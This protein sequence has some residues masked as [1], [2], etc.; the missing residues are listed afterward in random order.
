MHRI[1]VFTLSLAVAAPAAAEVRASSAT[2]FALESRATV[3][4]PPADVYAAL[5][6][7]GRWWDPQHTYSG[8]AAN[9]TLDPRVDGCFCEA[10]PAGGGSI[11]HGR[12]VY[13]RPGQTLRFQ[14]ALGPLQSEGVTGSLTWSLRAVDGGTEITQ[15]YV[16]GGYMRGGFEPVAPI[17]DRVMNTQ[18]LRLANYIRSPT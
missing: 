7:I 13:A 14:G 10:I 6:R 8:D 1:C 5:A 15:T 9:L 17:V 12:V 16:V 4:V 18:L 11:E 2:G 3:Q